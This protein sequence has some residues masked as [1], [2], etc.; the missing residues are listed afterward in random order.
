VADWSAQLYWEDV[1]EGAPVPEVAFPLT[2][3]RLVVHAGANHDFAPI[4][5]N[6]DIARSQGAP[7][8]YVN[9]VFLLGMWERAVREFIGL[10]GVVRQIGPFRMTRFTVVGQTAVVRGSVARKW[11]EGGVGYLD[12]AM[13]TAVEDGDSVVG[14]VLV[15][16]P[17]RT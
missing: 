10:D 5:H 13:R 6:A 17:R 12:L 14:T 16:L 11:S 3:H 7:D 4:H 1:E 8:M 2:V 9:N 15:T